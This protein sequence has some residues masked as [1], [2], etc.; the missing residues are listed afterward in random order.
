[1]YGIMLSN[2]NMYKG[3]K[4]SKY[5]QNLLKL[6]FVML[7]TVGQGSGYDFH[8]RTLLTSIEDF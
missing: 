3:L 1:M 2:G 8:F 4:G 5:K 7:I 6:L